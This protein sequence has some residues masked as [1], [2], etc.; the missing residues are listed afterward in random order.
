VGELL[1]DGTVVENSE[2]TVFATEQMSTDNLFGWFDIE[3]NCECPPTEPCATPAPAPGTPPGETAHTGP[4]SDICVET[5]DASTPYQECHDILAGD[6]MPVGSVCVEVVDRDG[7]P[8]LE[9]SFSSAAQ[10]TFVTNDIWIGENFTSIP[11]DED[12]ALDTENF[13]YYWCNSTGE[14]EWK[15]GFPLK[16]SYNCEDLDSFSLALLVQSTLGQLAE[17]GSVLADT[18]IVA[19]AL[20]HEAESSDGSFGWFDIDIMCECVPGE[21]PAQAPVEVV[22]DSPTEEDCYDIMAGEADVAGTVCFKVRGDQLDITFTAKPEYGFASTEFW[23]GE[24]IKDVPLDEDGELDTENF[25]YFWCNSTGGDTF[26][27]EIEFKWSYMCDGSDTFDLDVVAHATIGK[28][29]DDGTVDPSTEFSAFAME[30]DATNYEGSYLDLAFSC[31]AT[32]TGTITPDTSVCAPSID[33]VDEDFEFQDG[34][35]WH[36]NKPYFFGKGITSESG[37]FT[38]FLGRIGNTNN[39][40]T[41]SFDIPPAGGVAADSVT[42]SFDLYQI[43]QWTS[44]DSFDVE[45]GGTLVD[46]G[47]G[48]WF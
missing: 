14:S 41:E 1:E 39:D 24:D 19:F 46:L 44:D 15:T 9:V 48:D 25:P 27:T 47:D 33:L 29:L 43:D 38:N 34:K 23:V 16:W 32:T 11:Y 30:H 6:A 2:L 21:S 4:K 42:M 12:G 36:W 7:E 28:L 18:E 22:I 45:I 20:E 10:W 13:P 8:F 26:D 31:K 5:T 37:S 17:D 3:I 35:S 40:I